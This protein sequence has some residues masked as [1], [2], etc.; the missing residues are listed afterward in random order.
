MLETA[1]FISPENHH[2]HLQTIGFHLI[3]ESCAGT[4]PV[5]I[6]V[7][8]NFAEDDYRC[9]SCCTQICRLPTG[10]LTVAR[11]ALNHS[12]AP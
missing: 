6:F 4:V 3:E 8:V 2:N 11:I 9:C 7:I 12:K 1:M 10:Y 5:N